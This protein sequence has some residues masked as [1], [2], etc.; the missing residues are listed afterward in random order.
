MILA[1][2]RKINAFQELAKQDKEYWL[3]KEFDLNI[4]INKL[5]LGIIG[6]GR[7]GSSLAENFLH[8]LIILVFMI[9]IWCIL[10]NFWI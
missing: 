10:Q 3:G 5:S 7:I 6:L 2:T 8:F 9:H 1:L 4:K